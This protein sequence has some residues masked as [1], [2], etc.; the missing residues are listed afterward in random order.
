MW[1]TLPVRLAPLAKLIISIFS[2]I[3]FFRQL[4]AHSFDFF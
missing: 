3:D 2:I 1:L 4:V